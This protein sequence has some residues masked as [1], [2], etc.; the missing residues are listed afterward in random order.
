MSGSDLRYTLAADMSIGHA[1]SIADVNGDFEP[2][3]LL[4]TAASGEETELSYETLSLNQE[5]NQFEWLE[6][7]APPPNLK[8][9]GQ[10][11]FADFDSDGQI[12]HLL[13]ACR[14]LACLQSAIFVRKKDGQ[15]IQ[16]IFELIRFEL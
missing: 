2:D 8:V 5:S 10:S 14:D 16:K 7:Y 3:L 13:P 9:Y 6:S 4:T 11:L 15:V 12:E 1:H